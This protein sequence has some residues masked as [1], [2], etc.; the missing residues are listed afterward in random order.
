MVRCC[1]LS[2][3]GDELLVIADAKSLMVVARFVS[4]KL[5][6]MEGVLSTATHFRLKT[7][8]RDGLLF[9]EDAA[10]ERISVAP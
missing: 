10:P 1:Y 9:E 3:G 6:S 5:S 4:E 2:S 8:K 7:Y